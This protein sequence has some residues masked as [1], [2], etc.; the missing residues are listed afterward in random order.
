MPASH[1]HQQVAAVVAYFTPDEGEKSHVKAKLFDGIGSGQAQMRQSD[2][3][4]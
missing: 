2:G 3:V 1:F 4:P